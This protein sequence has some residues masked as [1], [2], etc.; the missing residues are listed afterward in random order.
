MPNEKI[1][2]MSRG[3]STMSVFIY[4]T[5]IILNGILGSFYIN[6]IFGSE[7]KAYHYLVDA[8][9]H[10]PLFPILS[11]A[12]YLLI[13]YDTIPRCMEGRAPK[14][15]KNV[16]IIHNGTLAIFSFIAF[17]NFIWEVCVP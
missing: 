13:T 16:T 8:G 10:Q 5:V 15:L 14:S 11:V 3:R 2:T 1:G 17:V 9:L 7:I 6:E 12:L 4:S